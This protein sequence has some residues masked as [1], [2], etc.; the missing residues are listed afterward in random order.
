MDVVLL[1]D[2]SPGL[3]V[4]AQVRRRFNSQVHFSSSLATKEFFLVVCFS[5]SSFPLSEE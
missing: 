3:A 4:A 2:F 5:F 1:W